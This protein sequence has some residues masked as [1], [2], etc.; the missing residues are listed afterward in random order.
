M[1]QEELIARAIRLA[2]QQ[3]REERDRQSQLVT[4]AAVSAA[5]AN[6]TQQVNALRKPD[7]PPFDRDNIHIW[8]KRL[9]NAYT[10]S[11]VVSPKAKFA[12]LESKFDVKADPKINSFLYGDQTLDDWTNFL[13]YLREKYGRTRRQEVQTILNGTPRE[14]RRPSQLLELIKE[15]AGKTTLDDIFKELVMKEMPKELKLLVAAQVEG[16][17]AEK[18]AQYLDKHFDH[19]GK[20]LHSEPTTSINH[21]ANL[22]PPQQQQPQK[23][24]FTAP[25]QP[26][27]DDEPEVSAVRFKAGQ[28]QSFNV[29]NRSAS[30]TRGRAG[31]NNNNFAR[32]NS[33]SG[34]FSS[35]AGASSNN[36]NAN[37]KKV[38]SYHSNYGT[39]AE[40]CEGNWCS[41]HT[42]NSIP[43]KGQASR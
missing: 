36:A 33:S 7:L 2:L 5:L 15:R 1:E 10:R 14:D 22:K 20:L 24:S 13:Q 18:T 42:R 4:Q 26:D 21:V 6:Q 43:P 3:D 31:H 40:R 9:E 19:K 38:C 11:N 41:M 16:L 32:S 28:R 39:Q 8:I 23:T 35:G 27:V 12:F 25:F 37:D 30:S 34:R 17:N 29:L